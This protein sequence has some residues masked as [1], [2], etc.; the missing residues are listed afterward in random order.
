MMDGVDGRRGRLG[1]GERMV[2]DTRDSPSPPFTTSPYHNHLQH[3]KKTKGKDG[4]LTGGLEV[5]TKGDVWWWLLG[6]RRGKGH[7]LLP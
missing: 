4:R 6:R 1:L 3:P 2:G 7:N 5:V